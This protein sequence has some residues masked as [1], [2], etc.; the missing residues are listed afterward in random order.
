MKE[1]D[2]TTNYT[3]PTYEKLYYL[4]YRTNFNPKTRLYKMNTSFYMK[5]LT[6]NHG[7]SIYTIWRPA[8]RDGYSPLGDIAVKGVNMPKFKTVIVSGAVAKPVDYEI[9]YDNNVIYNKET[10]NYNNKF[11]QVFLI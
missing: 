8:S 4:R 3:G 1:N 6:L 2:K 9:V 10:K 11:S 5:I 7:T